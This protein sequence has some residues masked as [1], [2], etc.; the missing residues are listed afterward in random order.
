MYVGQLCIVA[1]NNTQWKDGKDSWH[2]SKKT[3]TTFV[4]WHQINGSLIKS[5]AKLLQR[6]LDSKVFWH[7]QTM[8]VN[9]VP[10]K[11]LSIPRNT[12][13]CTYLRTVIGNLRPTGRMRPASQIRVAREASYRV[14][15]LIS[16]Q[17]IYN[18]MA[19]C[20]FQSEDK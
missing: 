2:M 8:Y 17:R 3:F 6:N 4:I 1:C 7:V 15:F 12:V 14:K 16:K 20:L 18:V 13:Y 11:Q 10:A 9:H 5:L 19:T